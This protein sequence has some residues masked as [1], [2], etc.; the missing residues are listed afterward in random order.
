MV[1]DHYGVISRRGAASVG[2]ST[3]AIRC[4]V[5]TGEWI[6][7]HPS[8]FRVRAA[9]R[10]WHGDLI[11][12]TMY[13][14]GIASHRAAAQ[15]HGIAVD[16]PIPVEVTV[17]ATWR[18][19]TPNGVIVHRSSQFEMSRSVTR[20]S[21]RATGVPR[22]VVD[23]A[24]LLSTVELRAIVDQVIREGKARLSDL[25]SVSV[26]HRKRGRSGPPALAR[27]LAGRLAD[28]R[29]ALS[30]W[31]NLVADVLLASGLPRPEIEYPVHI[32]RRNRTLHVDLAYPENRLVI[33]LDSVKWHHN[34]EAFERDRARYRDL[35][36]EGFVVLPLTWRQFVEEM[37]VFID[38]LRVL[39][40]RSP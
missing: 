24:S 4:R 26:Q 37:D 28:D 6:Q 32:R 16:R 21:I 8:V 40:E 15:L 17:P 2:L 13:T 25:W 19:A 10:S 29:I 9:L 14:G 7:V 18:R 20:N 31:S 27:C 35:A 38:Q 23:L 30:E 1:R 34:L 33:E 5:A 36:A 12:A 3:K 11:A 22:T 39:V